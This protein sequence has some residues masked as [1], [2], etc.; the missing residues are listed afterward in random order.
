MQATGVEAFTTK[1]ITG[2]NNAV[3]LWV[4]TVQNAGYAFAIVLVIIAVIR[5]RGGHGTEALWEVASAFIIAGF[6]FYAEELLGAIK[7]GVA[8][9]ATSAATVEVAVLWELGQQALV[10]TG[11]AGWL[12]WKHHATR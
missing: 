3:T 10:I 9:A 4:G 1:G 7:P 2:I 12:R 5:S 8:Q 11:L 6:M